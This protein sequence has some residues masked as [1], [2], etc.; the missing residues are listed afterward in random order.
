VH[1]GRSINPSFYWR[2]P[3]FF[4]YSRVAIFL[5][6]KFILV[7]FASGQRMC[8]T[9]FW[10]STPLHFISICELSGFDL[11]T[12]K[13]LRFNTYMDG[14]LKDLTQGVSF[15]N[16]GTVN[17]IPIESLGFFAKLNTLIIKDSKLPTVKQKL[18]RKG[19]KRI[20]HL[21]LHSNGIKTVERLAFRE[22]TDLKFIRLAENEFE[23]LPFNIF[24]H[25][26]GLEN[27]DFSKNKIQS[28]NPKL[29]HNLPRL[30]V[31]QFEGNLCASKNINCHS[32]SNCNLNFTELN[33]DLKK[34]HQ[35]CEETP[36]CAVQNKIPSN[37]F[38]A[39]DDNS[40]KLMGF[41]TDIGEVFDTT[42][43][44]IFWRQFV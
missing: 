18:F 42:N 6:I 26:P 27:I 11:S 4:R 23:S 25:N 5:L 28:V 33:E 39:I 30:N 29:F 20:K 2:L 19:F 31:F 16:A 44:K 13:E 43:W 22:M 15:E 1:S 14:V 10:S 17:S 35:N 34:C 12:E 9:G 8:G 41:S 32:L 24:L 37:I 38:Q 36:Q 3:N 40:E 21:D 7:S